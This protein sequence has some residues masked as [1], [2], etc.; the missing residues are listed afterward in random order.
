MK[1]G[2]KIIIAGLLVYGGFKIKE[3]ID[4]MPYEEK[5]NHF[6]LLLQQNKPFEAQEVLTMQLQKE[7]SI[8]KISTLIREQNLTKTQDVIWFDGLKNEGNYTLEGDF[9][10]SNK[11]KVPAVFSFLR[12]PEEEIKIHTLQIGDTLFSSSENNRTDFLE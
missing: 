8:E 10:F 3:I 2:Y 1:P 5:A 12:D 6:A 9:V 11:H 7:V 4:V